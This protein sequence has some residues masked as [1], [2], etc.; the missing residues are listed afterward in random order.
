MPNTYERDLVKTG[1]DRFIEYIE[2]EHGT[3]SCNRV[4]EL[5]HPPR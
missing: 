2:K 5:F 1:M 4:K 3:Y